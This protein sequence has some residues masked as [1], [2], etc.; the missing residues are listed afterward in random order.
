MC[1]KYGNSWFLDFRSLLCSF[2]VLFPF[3]KNGILGSLSREYKSRGQVCVFHLHPKNTN[4]SPFLE[5]CILVSCLSFFLSP[6]THF[7]SFS[8][9]ESTPVHPQTCARLTSSQPHLISRSSFQKLKFGFLKS[10]F[11]NGKISFSRNS[12]C[13]FLKYRID[14][15]RRRWVEVLE[16]WWSGKG[17]EV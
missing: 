11:P 2:R 13:W 3:N 12:R 17:R 10:W 4:Q 5:F 7:F 6:K 8:K 16:F 9:T 1:T 14:F 15:G